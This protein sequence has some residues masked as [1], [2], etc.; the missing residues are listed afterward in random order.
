MGRPDAAEVGLLCRVGRD[1]RARR[2]PMAQVRRRV[3]VCS[4]VTMRAF[5]VGEQR[6]H[7]TAGHWQ[8]SSMSSCS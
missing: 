2:S 8:A 6:Q 1:P 7:T 5:C 3:C 4:S